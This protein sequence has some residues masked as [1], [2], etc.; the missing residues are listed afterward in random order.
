MRR[1]VEDTTARTV[2][3]YNDVQGHCVVILRGCQTGWYYALVD[4]HYKIISFEGYVA[5]GDSIEAALA[6]ATEAIEREAR[7]RQGVIA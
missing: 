7:W 3:T 5:G 6:S 2:A 1:G 4:G